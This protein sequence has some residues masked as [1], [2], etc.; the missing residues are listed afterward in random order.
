[1]A[2]GRATL[3]LIAAAV[4]FMFLMKQGTVDT[5]KDWAPHWGLL[6]YYAVFFFGGWSLYR[7]REHLD[8][9]VRRWRTWLILGC[10]VWPVMAG[11]TVATIGHLR[12]KEVM[13]AETYWAVRSAAA[14]T[15]VVFTF[16][17]IWG[18]I[19]ATRRYFSGERPWVRWWADSSYWCYLMS[20][21][22]LVALQLALERSP[23]PLVL[24]W[25]IVL[26]V[27]ML[28]LL[29]TYQAFVRYTVIG[30]VLNGRRVKT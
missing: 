24:K 28:V 9:L 18:L 16:C 21:F 7:H 8:P 14:V 13:D 15:G 4:P 20:L 23:M 1:V 11:T 22:P 10:L 3:W 5:P 17:V 19:G 12:G 29:A 6:G 26:G 2:L 25:A 27:S 30:R